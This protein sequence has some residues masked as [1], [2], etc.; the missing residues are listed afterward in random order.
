MC[1]QLKANRMKTNG[2]KLNWLIPIMGIALVAG[3]LLA[4]ATY[5]KLEHEDHA[6][7]E[8]IARMQRL[9]RDLQLCAVLRTIRDGD[10]NSAAR[11]L[12]LWLCSDIVALN[13]QLAS[14][15]AGDRSLIRNAF[16]RF[17]LIRPASAELLTEEG[18][19]L[20]SDQVEAET[21]LARALA[22]IRPGHSG[23]ASLP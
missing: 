6:A 5:L 15:D 22:A 4:A 12:D 13:S 10:M 20:R 3:G 9:Q 2:M 11:D 8:S 16:A 23:L 1:N 21:I 19:E 7:Q 17:A 18:H 14:V